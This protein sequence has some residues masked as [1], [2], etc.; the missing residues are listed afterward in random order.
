VTRRLLPLALAFLAVLVVVSPAGGAD[1]ANELSRV[2]DRIAEVRSQISAV[3]ADRS[4][5]ATAVLEAADALDAAER[6]VTRASVELD[7]VAASL[8]DR[9]AALDTV[10]GELAVQLRQ[11]EETRALRDG[12]RSE[13]EQWALDAYMSGGTAQPSIAF[14]AS[15]VSDVSVG[16]AYLEVLTRHSAGI[17]DRYGELVASEEAQEDEIR[18]VEDSILL[19]VAELQTLEHRLEELNLALEVRRSELSAAYANQRQLL[20]DIDAEIEEFEGELAALSREESSIRSQIAEA[21]SSSSSSS[22][23]AS[24]G[25]FVRP[26]PGPI[27]SGFGMRIH[28]ITGDRRMHNGVDM[29]GALGDPIRSS[30]SGRVIFAGV[31]GGYGNAV[32]IDHGGGMVTLYGHQSRIAVTNGES[33]QA[34]Q[35]IGYV[36]STGQSTGP[37]LHF[38]VRI[39]GGPVNPAKYLGPGS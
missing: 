23:S 15:F 1:Q 16:V 14:N 8:V 38:E 5:L 25:G 7:R 11:L 36:G 27:S 4:D 24:S 17:A 33:V 34:G 39:N 18:R 26:V 12:A 3:E 10:R 32:M 28:P 29:N 9:R 30:R 19:E 6:E 35:V 20:D 37:H 13:A 22:S 21:A 31:K 2:R